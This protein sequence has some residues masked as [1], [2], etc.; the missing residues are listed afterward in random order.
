MDAHAGTLVQGCI[1]HRRRRRAFDWDARRV[2][3]L[4][5]ADYVSSVLGSLPGVDPN[6]PALQATLQSLRDQ[7]APK[8]DGSKD[9]DKGKEE[10]E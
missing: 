8:G 10:E 7:G 4:N 9:A 2:Q 6:D 5:D 3:V 1:S